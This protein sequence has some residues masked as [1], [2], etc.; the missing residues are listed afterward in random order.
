MNQL[1]EAIGEVLGMTV[2]KEYCL[3]APATS[4][5]PGPI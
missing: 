1:T 3:A 5:T 4:A 2:E